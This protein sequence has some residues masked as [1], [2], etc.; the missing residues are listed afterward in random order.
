MY[1]LSLDQ[2]V[3]SFQCNTLQHC[4]VKVLRPVMHQVWLQENI[5]AIFLG[6]PITNMMLHNI[7]GNVATF[8]PGPGVASQYYGYIYI[9]CYIIDIMDI[10][11]K[12][13]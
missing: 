7:M 12:A 11:R 9:R 13:E 5:L 6:F 8:L 2:T 3:A 10:L 4:C 1:P